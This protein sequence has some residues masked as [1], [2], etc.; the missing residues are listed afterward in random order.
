[1]DAMEPETKFS[2]LQSDEVMISR[3]SRWV[4]VV[5]AGSAVIMLALA[6][7]SSGQVSGLTQRADTS[8]KPVSIDGIAGAGRAPGRQIM[9]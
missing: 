7:I 2:D 1:M 4:V 6:A 3:P 9:Q 5:L 8:V